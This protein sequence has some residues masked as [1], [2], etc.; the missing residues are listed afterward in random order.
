MAVSWEEFVRTQAE[1]MLTSAFRVLGH[2]A[3]AEDVVQDVLIEILNKKMFPGIAKQPGLLRH[4]TTCRA[5]DRLRRRRVNFPLTEAEKTGREDFPGKE[6]IARDLEEQ[7]RLALK[8]LPPREAEVFCLVFFEGMSSREIAE[9]ASISLGAVAKSLSLA[10]K[11]LS[12]IF[13]IER[14]GW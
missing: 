10:R 9:V 1:P 4:I 12:E 5:L 11:R 3:D 7:L 8:E 6:L 14:A 2:S 13:S